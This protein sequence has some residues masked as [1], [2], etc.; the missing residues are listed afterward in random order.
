M[1][2]K[3]TYGNRISETINGG[4]AIELKCSGCKMTSNVIVECTDE[5]AEDDGS[6]DE[7]YSAGYNKCTEDMQDELQAKY[8]EGYDKC[9]E[10]M[11]GELQTMYNQGVAAGEN[12]LMDAHLANGN[13]TDFDYA[14]YGIGW[15]DESFK[16]NHDMAPTKMN[17][18]FFGSK[19]T[20]L[21]KI[22]RDRGVTLDLSKCPASSATFCL[23]TSSITHFPSIPRS[24]ITNASTSCSVIKNAKSLKVL[25]GLHGLTYWVYGTDEDGYESYN[26]GTTLPND[27]FQNLESLE[28]ILNFVAEVPPPCD[29]ECVCQIY[30]TCGIFTGTVNLSWSPNL[31]RETLLRVADALASERD[32]SDDWNFIIG[33][34]NMAKLTDEEIT[35]ITEKGWVVS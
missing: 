34:A 1:S 3:I 9:T 7:G 20:N 27:L 6:Y 23:S 5:P 22:L 25:E 15:T 35:A 8:T 28:E 4:E 11:Q 19:I 16:P 31:S 26:G 33:E 13:R 10:D 2:A 18:T 12:G 29:G 14:F 32:F 21:A 24:I 17:R 30:R